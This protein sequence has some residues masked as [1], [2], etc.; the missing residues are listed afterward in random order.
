VLAVA[1]PDVDDQTALFVTGYSVMFA[2]VN[3]A[4]LDVMDDRLERRVLIS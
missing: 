3:R 4:P 2:S 1:G